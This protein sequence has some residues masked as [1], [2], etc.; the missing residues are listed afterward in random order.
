MNAQDHPHRPEIAPLPRPQTA[1]GT[2]RRVGVEIE[3][4]GLPE[5][6]VARL[7]AETLGGEVQEAKRGKLVAGTELGDIEVY[8]D[9]RFL[10]EAKDGLAGRMRE[11]AGSVVP[12]EI[13]TEPV[14]PLQIAR[15]D[16]LMDALRGAGATGT[17]AGLFLGFGVHFNPEITAPTIDA[18]LPVL[19][20]FTLAEDCLREDAHID[21]SRRVLPFVDPYPRGLIDAL[22]KDPPADLT[23]LI[24]LYLHH[25][26][27]RNY[28]LDM[29]ALFTHLDRDRAAQKLDLAGVK[30]RPT[31]HLRLPD[32]RIDEADWSL[33]LEWNR[34]V[35]VERIAED[36]PLMD[37]LRSAWRDHRDTL[38]STRGDWAR[39]SRKLIE[40]AGH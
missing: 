21:L 4:G 29:I 39:R 18:I 3:L 23:G 16:H 26:A 15:L 19:T 40:E 17:R 13:V 36:A 14:S 25:A 10:N 33:A 34:W 24:D 35:W 38:L 6:D 7:V 37:R 2:A 9:S 20:A 11:L 8:L 30:G 27:S 28:A 31:Y 12:I 22:V 5:E 32:C 1:A